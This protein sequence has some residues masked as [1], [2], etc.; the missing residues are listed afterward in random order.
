VQWIGNNAAAVQAIS[1]VALLFV[2]GVYVWFTKTLADQA[3]RNQ[4]P[5]VYM[6]IDARK[7]T[8]LQL[9]IG[10]V[11]ERAANNIQIAVE[12]KDG[13]G[14]RNPLA[15][16][17]GSERTLNLDVLR[18]LAP[19]RSGIPYLAPG[20]VY[21]WDLLGLGRVDE[22]VNG[23]PG[24]NTVDVRIRYEAD[25]HKYKEDTHFDFAVMSGMRI[26]T[27]DDPLADIADHLRKISRQLDSNAHS[28]RDPFGLTTRCEFCGSAIQR[29]AVKCSSCR[30]WLIPLRQRIRLRVR[31][32]LGASVGSSE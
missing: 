18:D 21:R 5:Y 10:N 26:Q 27:F 24:E 23:R 29:S 19:V 32:A 15:Q 30:E 14:R 16:P 22:L 12:P 4:R 9:L 28:S 6:D 13:R 20:R 1:T 7:G 11:G 2:T 17:D 3:R 25:G 31:S 8:D